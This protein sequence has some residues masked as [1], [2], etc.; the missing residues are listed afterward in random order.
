MPKLGIIAGGGA[1]PG[2]IIEACRRTDREFYVLA[3]QGSAEPDVIGDAPA[4]WIRMSSLSR[5]I[6]A[7]RREG[8][9]E[10]VLAGNIPRPTLGELM[11]DIRSAKFMAKVGTRMLGDNSILSAVVRELEEAEGFRVVALESL[12]DDILAQPRTYGSVEPTADDRADIKRGLEVAR[13]L[14]RLDIGQAAVV[15]NGS[16]LGVEG[17]EGTDQLISRCAPFVERN[18]P[19]GVLVKVAK[20]GQE[21]RADLPAVGVSTVR[22]AALAGL[23][24]IAVEAQGALIV[25]RAE[26]V[27]AA[28]RAGLFVVGV[29]ADG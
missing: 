16:V 11:R 29:A 17:V 14:G 22:N 28:D 20:P 4:E 13:A 2:Q 26:T 15:Q 24:G 18:T 6:A 3:F 21:R 7:A 10:I 8:V 25:G 5:A 23:R 19:G 9:E 27:E 12:L 1:L